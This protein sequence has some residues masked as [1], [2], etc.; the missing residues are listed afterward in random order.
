MLLNLFCYS[1]ETVDRKNVSSYYER[2]RDLKTAI[3]YTEPPERLQKNKTRSS[4][5]SDGILREIKQLNNAKY[6]SELRKELFDGA[7]DNLGLRQRSGNDSAENMEKYYANIQEKLGEEMLALTRNLKE[8]TL[9]AS[10]I[11][12]KDTDMVTK[13]AKLAHQNTGSLEKESKKLD[14]HNKRACK[15]WLWMMIGLVIAIFIGKLSI[16]FEIQ[17]IYKQLFLFHSNGTIYETNEEK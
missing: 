1:S 7:D 17:I 10:K 9:T 13:S 3:N 4:E 16:P 14:E 12:R 11:I 8:Q 2:V 15:C 5:P 6:N